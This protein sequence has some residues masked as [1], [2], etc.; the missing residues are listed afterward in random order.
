MDWQ[1]IGE[2]IVTILLS[3]AATVGG[4]ATYVKRKG[5]AVVQAA[6]SIEAAA[7][8]VTAIATE[9]KAKVAPPAS[10]AAIVAAL[11][12]MNDQL[13]AALLTNS[14]GAFE[15]VTL[16]QATAQR[17]AGA[18]VHQPAVTPAPGYVPP[19][20]GGIG[21]FTVNGLVND[22]E[23][24]QRELRRTMVEMGYDPEVARAVPDFPEGM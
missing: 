4:I 22:P 18:P 23:E 15:R 19:N 21:R 14:A 6:A 13:L 12:H 11:L 8:Q 2:A 10:D 16:A 17:V 9:T 20:G 3:A 7:G 1:Q 5:P 24:Y